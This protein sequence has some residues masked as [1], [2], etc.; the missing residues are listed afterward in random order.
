MPSESNVH[1]IGNNGN[2]TILNNARAQS[3]YNPTTIPILRQ[4]S[5]NYSPILSASSS[6][7]TITTDGGGGG[8]NSGMDNEAVGDPNELGIPRSSIHRWLPKTQRNL[9]QKQAELF[10]KP[11]KKT[12][13]KKVETDIF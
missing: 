10:A 7:T 9:L 5:K 1:K 12:S 3:V 13:P 8:R 6:L 11:T 4:S 2:V